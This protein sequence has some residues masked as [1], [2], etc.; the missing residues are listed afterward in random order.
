MPR[1]TMSRQV[2][3]GML[4]IGMGLLFLLDNLDIWDFGRALQFWP[5]MLIALGISVVY[6][7]VAGRRL[8][9]VEV[10]N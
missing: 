7:A 6:R 1:K 2:I 10:R 4:V 5:V 9:G 3:V 8:A